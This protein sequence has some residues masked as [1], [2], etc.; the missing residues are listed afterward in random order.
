MKDV[1]AVFRDLLYV[2]TC[3]IVAE[4][5]AKPS[6]GYQGAGAFSQVPH[7]AHLPAPCVRP[8]PPF[9]IL[10]C[11]LAHVLRREAFVAPRCTSGKP[12]PARAYGTGPCTGGCH[13]PRIARTVENSVACPQKRIHCQSNAHAA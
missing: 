9:P 11:R 12:N 8:S 2:C 1:L 6:P 13:R 5:Y 3:S 4:S 7:L 10:P